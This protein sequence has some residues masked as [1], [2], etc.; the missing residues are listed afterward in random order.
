[1]K[2]PFETLA[3]KWVGYAERLYAPVPHLKNACVCVRRGGGG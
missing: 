1:M 3:Y 2:K